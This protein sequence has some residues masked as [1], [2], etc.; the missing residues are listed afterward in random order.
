M[1]GIP[2]ARIIVRNEF[3]HPELLK[4]MRNCA[5]FRAEATTTVGCAVVLKSLGSEHFNGRALHRS[6]QDSA[7]GATRS[8]R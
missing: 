6:G 2:A 7:T 8:R 4:A 1:S 5:S 3:K